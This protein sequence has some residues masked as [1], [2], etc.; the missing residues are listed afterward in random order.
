MLTFDDGYKDHI[1][2]VFPE[3]IK[4][5]IRGLFFPS[6]KAILENVVMDVDCIHLIIASISD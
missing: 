3:L 2:Y 5:K 6:A 4:R 1:R